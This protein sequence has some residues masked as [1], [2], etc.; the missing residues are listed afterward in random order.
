MSCLGCGHYLQVMFTG[1]LEA[2]LSYNDMSSEYESNSLD[3]VTARGPS[4]KCDVV[5]K[6]AQG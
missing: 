3:N 6:E 4:M 1:V 5:K 2:Q